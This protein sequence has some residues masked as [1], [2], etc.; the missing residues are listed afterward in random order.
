MPTELLDWL[1]NNCAHCIQRSAGYPGKREKPKY[2]CLVNV[3]LSTAAQGDQVSA[4]CCTYICYVYLC[5]CIYVYM[6]V[7]ICDESGKMSSAF[8]RRLTSTQSK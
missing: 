1:P 5:I 4:P 3:L 2:L 6:C 7:C 8:A